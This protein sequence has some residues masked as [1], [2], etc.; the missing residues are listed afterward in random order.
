MGNVERR[1]AVEFRFDGGV[2]TGPAVRYGDVA[3]G[4]SGLERF[5]ASPWRSGLDTAPLVLQHDRERVIA[6]QPDALAFTDR[7]ASLDLRAVLPEDGAEARLVRR[8]ALR[9]LSVG[10]VALEEHRADGV[11]VI[12]GAH[13]DHVALVDRPAYPGSTVE[14]RQ[15][16]RD[17]WLR[18][19]VPFDTALV[20]TCQGGGCETVQFPARSFDDALAEGREVLA[21][22]GQG[23]ASVLG[24][25][26]RGTLLLDT[27]RD[28]LRI[29]LDGPTDTA[30]ARQVVESARVGPV[31]A[32]PIIDI[33]ASDYTDD[34][35]LRTF[36]RV[37]LRGIL[38]KATPN[39]AGH[40]P[41]AIR[42]VPE[43]R[44]RIWL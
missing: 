5:A 17:A 10:F 25:R 34:G 8:R 13:L 38:V 6:T 32:R 21:V 26:R 19:T 20:C 12:T 7:P 9:G 4:P 11:R 39:D 36:H 14:I 44:R 31:Y 33:E 40:I 30:A 18:A 1:A 15:R 23:F 43:A 28:G 37:A 29:G 27:N 42:G 24:S 2:L 41:A 22:G 3:S 16:M 35:P